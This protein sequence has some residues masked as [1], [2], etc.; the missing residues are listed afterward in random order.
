MPTTKKP[1]T[2]LRRKAP[3][4]GVV[5][6]ARRKAMLKLAKETEDMSLRI[7][8][9]SNDIAANTEKMLAYMKEFNDKTIPAEYGNFEYDIPSGRGSTVV[10][11][12]EF[13]ERVT[14]EEFMECVSVGVTKAKEVL[15][16]KELKECS[17]FTPGKPGEARVKY[18]KKKK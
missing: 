16:A 5:P 13:K 15:S 11:L 7:Q 8:E 2:R 1:R 6:E 14:E 18:A 17:T 4:H 9:I 12:A 3:T 10:H